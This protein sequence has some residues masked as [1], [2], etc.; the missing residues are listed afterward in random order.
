MHRS[1]FST[2]I[3]T[4]NVTR[5]KTS[6]SALLG[7]TAL[8]SLG[9]STPVMADDFVITSAT[10][11]NNGTAGSYTD[12]AKSDTYNTVSIGVS[13]KGSNGMSLTGNVSNS[14]SN[15][16]VSGAITRLGFNWEF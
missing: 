5:V 9:L 4:P 16:K 15:N 6:L 11:T 12:S 2:N 10:T 14:T 8:L 13:Y 3:K 1:I 7:A